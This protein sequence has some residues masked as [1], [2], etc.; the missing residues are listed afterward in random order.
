MASLKHPAAYEQE[1]TET[2]T[3][4][5]YQ[6]TDV[7]PGKPVFKGNRVYCNPADVDEVTAGVK[8]YLQAKYNKQSL[9]LLWGFYDEVKH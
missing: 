8:D 6:T 4:E 3:V 2:E 1:D 5:V 9:E 7:P